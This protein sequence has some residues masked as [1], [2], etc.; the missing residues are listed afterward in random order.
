MAYFPLPQP[1]DSLRHQRPVPRISGTAMPHGVFLSTG[2]VGSASGLSLFV[3]GFT[4]VCLG[5]LSAVPTYLIAWLA[6]QQLH[7][8][9]PALMLQIGGPAD[10]VTAAL[11][12]AA[13][14]LV[15]LLV[16]LLVLRVSPLAGYHAAEHMTVHAIEHFGIYGWE[17]Y[18][19]AM[20]RAHPRCGSNLLSGVLP[21]L[22]V[23][24]PLAGVAP[25]VAVVVALVGWRTRHAIGFFLQNTFTTKPP[26]ARQLEAGIGAGR[27]VLERWLATPATRLPLAHS[28]WRRGIPQ[29]VAGVMAATYAFGA[30]ADH[31]H[32]WLDW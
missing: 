17:P 26:T 8:S 30:V 4:I 27:R 7:L 11:C 21:A 18:V 9:L 6:E 20:P 10:P 23:G 2:N 13:I 12:R 25:V 32:T 28:L 29:L 14:N 19:A 1:S 15:S 24:L 16:F 22:T 3:T 31:L 5:L